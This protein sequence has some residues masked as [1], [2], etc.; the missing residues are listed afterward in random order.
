M[1][2]E[3]RY[4]RQ[5]DIVPI[6]LLNEKEISVIGIGAVGRNVTL[7]LASIGVQNLHI[8]DFDTVEEPNICTQGYLEADLG[9]YKVEATERQLKYINKTINLRPEI[10]RY[11]LNTTLG[12]IV[13]VC[14]DSMDTRNSIFRMFRKRAKQRG[15]NLED[16]IDTLLIDGR[17]SAETFRVL[18]IYD[19]ESLNYY[20]STL[21]T[22]EEA[23][24]GSCTA[25]ST[26]YCASGLACFEV[27]ILTK[28]LRNVPILKDMLV[29]LL[30]DEHIVLKK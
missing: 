4:S 22:D 21:F 23:Y 12:D 19:A 5:Q 30:S 6:D 17:M 3:E 7:Q 14:V 26:I 25:K 20:P 18:A 9:M 2:S 1:N 8:I 24:Q 10:N 15:L 29:N 16:K 28:W 13:F 11:R 27:S